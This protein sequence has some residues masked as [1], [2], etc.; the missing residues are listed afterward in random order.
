MPELLRVFLLYLDDL[1]APS[2]QLD[3]I[4]SDLMAQTNAILGKLKK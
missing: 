3:L 1:I 4:H 2:A